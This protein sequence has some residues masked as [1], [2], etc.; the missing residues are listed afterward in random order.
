MKNKLLST[1]SF[2]LLMMSFSFAQGIKYTKNDT[3]RY[4]VKNEIPR[5]FA[6][7]LWTGVEFPLQNKKSIYVSGIA[8]YG[9]NF[10]SNRQLIGWG[11]EFQYRSYLGKGDF[12]TNYPI[13]LAGQLMF[14]RLNDYLMVENG[15]FVNDVWTVSQIENKSSY[16]VYYAGILLGCQVFVNQVFTLDLNFGG[17][18]RLSQV[19]G[20]KSFTKYKNVSDLNYS[21]V[22]PRVGLVIGIIQH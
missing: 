2:V 22:M 4:I 15:Q 16:N 19:D 9:S 11:G 10:T 18:L 6:G 20:E 17:G 8:T 1:V 7:T 14:R 3:I 21:G 13:Y 5:F 12:V